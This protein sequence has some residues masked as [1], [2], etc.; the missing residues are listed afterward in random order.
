ME[1]QPRDSQ[2][3]RCFPKGNLFL[4]QVPGNYYHRENFHGGLCAPRNTLCALI[5]DSMGHIAEAEKEELQAQE[6][7]PEERNNVVHSF[8]QPAL[9]R[10]ILG[11]CVST[12]MQHSP[13]KTTALTVSH[14]HCIGCP[15]SSS[16]SFTGDSHAAWLGGSQV[17]WLKEEGRRTGL[18]P[19][20]RPKAGLSWDLST[21]GFPCSM[22]LWASPSPD[23]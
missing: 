11:T 5:P 7:V 12:C 9:A 13:L 4:L 21:A 19:W 22:P 1:L 20:L 3:Y 15:G 6:K 10:T 23:F 17:V 2:S 14:N 18:A 16:T 8:L